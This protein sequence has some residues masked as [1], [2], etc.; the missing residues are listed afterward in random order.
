MDES[1]SMDSKKMD[2]IGGFNSFIDEQ[3][4]I[5]N[6]KARLYLIKFNT[7]VKTLHKGIY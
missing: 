4:K 2:V 7:Q 5:E 3:K 1:G 6:D